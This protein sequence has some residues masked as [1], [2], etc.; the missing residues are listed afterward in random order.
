MHLQQ[1]CS[2]QPLF[3]KP[4]D[5][6]GSVIFSRNI[7]LIGKK[8]SFRSLDL[9]KDTDLIHHWVNQPY[10]L[11]FW[12]L[13]GNRERVYDLYYNIQRNSNGH[14]YMGLL[15]DQPICQFDVYRVLA[16]ELHQFVVADENDCGFH[17]LMAPNENPLPGLTLMIVQS[18]L[19]YY[20]S[21]QEAN[22]MY[23]EPDLTNRRSNRILQNIGFAYHHAI[24]MSYKTANLYSITKQQFHATYPLI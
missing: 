6:P 8:I 9:A 19:H 1:L 15:D 11:P 12:Q 4:L 14:S 22:R 23:A 10:A 21:F 7:E 20:F 13:E 16:D 24:E 3:L 2:L 5:Y 17:L 18:F